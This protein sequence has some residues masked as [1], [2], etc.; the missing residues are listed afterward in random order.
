MIR[1]FRVLLVLAIAAL[2]GHGLLRERYEIHPMR[3]GDSRLI[4]GYDFVEG[5]SYDSY[6][7][8]DG[9]LFDIYSLSQIESTE[10]DCKT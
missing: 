3:E 7:R 6:I 10:K 1:V 8:R 9:L 4:R 2:V 5:A